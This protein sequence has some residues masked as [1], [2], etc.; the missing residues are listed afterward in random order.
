[1]KTHITILAAAMLFIAAC[2]PSPK[3]H[4]DS[5][6][7]QNAE[8]TDEEAVKI[9]VEKRWEA[10]LARDM[11]AAYEFETPAYRA[12]NDIASYRSKYFNQIKWLG[13][14]VRDIARAKDLPDTMNVGVILDFESQGGHPGYTRVDEV[15]VKRDGLWWHVSKR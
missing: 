4:S 5:P 7:T 3:T 6:R 10:L 9:R 14:T 13:I 15:W 12:V 8:L 11:A 1:M 2:T